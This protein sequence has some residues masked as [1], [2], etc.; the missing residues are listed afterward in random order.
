[1]SIT[2]KLKRRQP[3]DKAKPIQKK[4]IIKYTNTQLSKWIKIQALRDILI[5]NSIRV[6]AESKMKHMVPRLEKN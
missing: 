1:M 4:S 6:K 3:I 5:E 2:N